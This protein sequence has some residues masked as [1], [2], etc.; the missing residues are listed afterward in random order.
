MGTKKGGQG[1]TREATAGSTVSPRSEGPGGGLAGGVLGAGARRSGNPCQHARPI[2]AVKVGLLGPTPCQ[3]Q[4][5]QR[6]LPR[7]WVQSLSVGGAFL[8][9][10]RRESYQPKRLAF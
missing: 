10:L 2:G 9:G 1:P 3:G 7:H 5:T 6:G 8:E 4:Q